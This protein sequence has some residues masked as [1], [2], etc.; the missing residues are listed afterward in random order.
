[1]GDSNNPTTSE[2]YEADDVEMYV[3]LLHQSRVL[4]SA[5]RYGSFWEN[6]AW[7][8]DFFDESKL[9]DSIKERE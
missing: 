4:R 6:E 3:A 1:M 5:L 2:T 7:V 9:S 8:N